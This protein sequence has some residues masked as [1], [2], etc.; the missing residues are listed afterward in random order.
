MTVPVKRR[1]DTSDGKGEPATPPDIAQAR[2]PLEWYEDATEN[3][4]DADGCSA[5][6][7]YGVSEAEAN[8]ISLR[9]KVMGMHPK[10]AWILIQLVMLVICL[11][12]IILVNSRFGG[13]FFWGL[14]VVVAPLVSAYFILF[15]VV[16]VRC[17]SCRGKMRYRTIR[18]ALG[19]GPQK[20]GTRILHGFVCTRC[21]EED[22]REIPFS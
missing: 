4:I 13:A 17:P 19:P 5:G 20:A 15:R 11:S 8:V 9:V 1:A 3:I 21:S 14:L 7:S 6:A 2:G 16:P 18:R 12:G 10:W 22:L